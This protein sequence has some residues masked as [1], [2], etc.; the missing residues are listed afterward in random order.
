MLKIRRKTKKFVS[1]AVLFGLLF[2][3][4]NPI[5][6]NADVFDIGNVGDF[7]AASFLGVPPITIEAA[8]RTYDK[9]S[10]MMDVDAYAEKYSQAPV[11]S[12]NNQVQGVTHKTD[13]PAVEVVFSAEGASGTPG[14]RMTAKA[15]PSFFKNGSETKDLY[16]TWYLKRNNCGLTKSSKPGDVGNCD[17]DGDNE[18][19]VNDWKIAATKIIVA[20]AFNS[21]ELDADGNKKVNYSNSNPDE[22]AASYKADEPKYCYV[23][24]QISGLD[25]ELT[26][27]EEEFNNPCPAGTKLSC[28]K[29]NQ[30]DTCEVLNPAY[31]PIEEKRI[32]DEIAAVKAWNADPANAE[33]PEYPKTEPLPYI[34]PKTIQRTTN[35]FCGV[36]GDDSSDF[37]CKITDD[38]DLRNFKATVACYND[39]EVA[40]CVKDSGNT[41]FPDT[42]PYTS[43]VF[44]KNNLC[45]SL[46]INDNKPPVPE[47]APLWLDAQNPLYNNLANQTCAKAL[48]TSKATASCTFKKTDEKICKHLFAQPSPKISEISGDGK[49]TLAEKEFWGTDPSVDSTN[50]KGKDE[51]NVVGLGVDTFSWMFSTGDQ[52]GVVI[53]GDSTFPTDHSDS[54]YKRTWA[55]SKNSCKALD[56]LIEDK[57]NLASGDKSNADKKG[58]YVEGA[59]GQ[60]CD[61]NNKSTCTGFLTAEIDLNQCLEENLLEP[62]DENSAKL[63]IQLDVA[64]KNPIND[65]NG[66]GDILN[67]SATGFNTQ[68]STSLVYKWTVLKSL[69]GSSDPIDGTSWI[70][71]T[72]KMENAESFSKKDAEGLNKKELNINLNLSQ[73]LLLEGMQSGK[74]YTGTFFLKI[75]TKINGTNA[76]GNQEAEGSVIVRVRSQQNEII[77]YPVTATN[78]GAL[79]MN[80]AVGSE[81]C[82]SSEEK[83]KCFVTAN[84]ILGLT[85]PSESING[86]P[87]L[88]NFSWTVN[89]LETSCDSS[90]SLQC[91]T[92]GN[93]L[94]IPVVGNEGEAV[95]VTAKAINTET[96]EL[97]EISRRFVII[98]P[99][100]VITSTNKSLLW[101]K[102]VG[103]YKS[104]T[105]NET[106]GEFESYPAYSETVFEAKSGENA[107]LKAN[108]YPASTESS[109]NFDW[110]IDGETRYEFNNKKEITF[111]LDKVIGDSYDVGLAAKYNP[112]SNSQL[113][114]LRLALYKNW[115]ISAQNTVEEDQEVNMQI[116]VVANSQVSENTN[117]SSGFASLISHLPENLIFLFKLALMASFLLL[118]TGIVATVIPEKILEEK[119]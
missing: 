42:T 89:S 99:Q 95:I 78:T 67:V 57:H 22:L 91:T 82:D 27:V 115:N 80:N 1:V 34:I 110:I 113:N 106:T 76:D 62:L 24:D 19:T 46:S 32:K 105:V 18:I 20:G 81:I 9:F 5:I 108:F 97:I 4:M 13:S 101:P 63:G 17:L 30:L 51:E 47:P 75:K 53:E 21:G 58:I 14:S 55:F 38:T 52:V 2:F 60:E 10:K 116:N 94:F 68:D 98:K 3:E 71:I 90:V 35:K 93:M 50:G 111:P 100:V 59:G 92:A 40:M 114:N 29:D 37:F 6:A 85:I 11:N 70:D 44:G 107:T 96:K 66:R 31:D 61:P 88:A 49:F 74:K 54:S 72:E 25:Y 16:F 118:L 77:I 45:S 33:D 87:K 103:L 109:A 26:R 64:P 84:E 86:K 12:A 41:L 36:V 39:N 112:G 65:P 73:A 117:M 23:R 69:D 56:R 79:V 104:L 15:V 43:V 48:E 83:S 8:K 28:A 102:Q 7:N 119:K